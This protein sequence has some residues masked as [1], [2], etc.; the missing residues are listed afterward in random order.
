MV[1]KHLEETW[2]LMCS[3]SA[4]VMQIAGFG[5]HLFADEYFS[6]EEGGGGASSLILIIQGI[7]YKAL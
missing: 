7:I 3:L 2:Q 5:F 1:H 4:G 6:L